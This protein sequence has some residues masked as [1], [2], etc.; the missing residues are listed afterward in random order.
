[1]Y[2]AEGLTLQGSACEPDEVIETLV[3]NKKTVREQFRAGKIIDGKTICAFAHC[4]WL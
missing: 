3:V 2:K 1:M 4:G